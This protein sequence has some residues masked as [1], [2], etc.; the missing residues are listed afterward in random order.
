M[1]GLSA[2][3]CAPAY[4]SDGTAHTYLGF[5]IGITNAPPPPRLVF[6]GPPH[7]QRVE[8][9]DVQIV[10]APDPGCDLFQYQGAYWMY[11]GGYWYTSYRYGGPYRV[12]E[13]RTVPHAV[14]VVPT[15]H[16]RHPP[17]GH[18]HY[19]QGWHG[20]KGHE[21]DKGHGHQGDQG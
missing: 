11:S 14:L 18:A 12:V 16:W 8:Y 13:V 4:S 2:I 6:Y 19:D 21:H 7:V 5:S 9:T 17:P 15:E 20:E 3:S 10:S 1:I